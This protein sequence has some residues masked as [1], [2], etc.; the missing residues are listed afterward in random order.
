MKGL[1]W[2]QLAGGKAASALLFLPVACCLLRLLSLACPTPAHPP[3]HACMPALC[4]PVCVSRWLQ[5][6]FDLLLLA[7]AMREEGYL[8]PSL[9]LWAVEN[10]ML[11]PVSRLA[12]KAAAGAEVVVTQPPLLFDR[13]ARWMEEAAA[14]RISDNVK[15]G[16]V[17]G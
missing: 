5:N 15:V 2:S 1:G 14:T 3:T 9:S 8:P 7:S 11:A 6:S 17:C 13:V 16:V 12:Q 10:P 4:L